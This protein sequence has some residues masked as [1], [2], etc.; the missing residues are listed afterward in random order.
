ML[1]SVIWSFCVKEVLRTYLCWGT[2]IKIAGKIIEPR[3]GWQLCVKPVIKVHCN[4]C[5]HKH[6]PTYI[7]ITKMTWT[8]WYDRKMENWMKSKI[9]ATDLYCVI[10][11]YK[12]CREF[13][14]SRQL[15]KWFQI[16]KRYQKHRMVSYHPTFRFHAVF[17]L[18]LKI[19]PKLYFSFSQYRNI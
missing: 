9:N 13:P 17:F 14:D 15:F 12:H 6:K 4:L 7:M 18:W 19:D 11:F 10:D 1:V 5:N 16:K 2:M 8:E 3:E